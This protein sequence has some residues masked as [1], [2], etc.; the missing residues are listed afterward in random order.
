[1]YKIFKI[2]TAF[3]KLVNFYHSTSLSY[4]LCFLS[5][6]ADSVALIKF[7]FGV[8][9]DSSA[10]VVSEKDLKDI[11]ELTS[12]LGSETNNQAASDSLPS[13]YQVCFHILI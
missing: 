7:L 11:E 13:Y 12:M 1:M 4:V 9:N 3:R 8:K 6:N 5:I 10:E 2:C